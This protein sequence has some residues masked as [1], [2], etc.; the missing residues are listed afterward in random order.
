MKGYGSEFALA[1]ESDVSECALP[2]CLCES[3]S[4]YACTSVA[5]QRL[6]CTNL[7]VSDGRILGKQPMETTTQAA[8]AQVTPTSA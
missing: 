2:M 8:N 6:Q 1:C 4:A 3:V 7:R 5:L